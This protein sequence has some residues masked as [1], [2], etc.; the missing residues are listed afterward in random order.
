[1]RKMGAVFDFL[2]NQEDLLR[3]YEHNRLPG[4]CQNLFKTMG[5]IDSLKIND[6]L[7]RFVAIVR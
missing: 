5:D 1:M 6:E 7:K 4:A 3:E 2:Y